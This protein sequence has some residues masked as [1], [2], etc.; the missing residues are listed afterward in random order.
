M[1]AILIIHGKCSIW[2]YRKDIETLLLHRASGNAFRIHSGFGLFISSFKPT[3]S[4][5]PFVK[6]TFCLQAAGTKVGS[7]RVRL[8]AYSMPIT[9]VSQKFCNTENFSLDG[10][11]QWFST[12]LM[13]PDPMEPDDALY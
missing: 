8:D 10:E 1:N 2:K 11:S 3:G 9:L 12:F 13:T 7:C 5:M 4:V 6:F